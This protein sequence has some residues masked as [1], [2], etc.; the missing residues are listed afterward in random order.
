MIYKLM[1][2]IR[3]H[4]P[5]RKTLEVYIIIT[6]V[7]GNLFPFDKYGNNII[8]NARFVMF[9]LNNEDMSINST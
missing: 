1:I 6:V 9:V 8:I 7:S 5:I 3:K 2:Q 4:S